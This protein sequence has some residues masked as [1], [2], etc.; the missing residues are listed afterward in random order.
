MQS[1]SNGRVS[2]SHVLQIV[3][4]NIRVSV[5]FQRKMASSAPFIEEIQS[6]QQEAD[7]VI[8]PL[9]EEINVASTEKN[10]AIMEVARLRNFV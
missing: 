5:N 10:T 8:A 9:A 3:S 2:T 7:L 4:V 1:T 6:L